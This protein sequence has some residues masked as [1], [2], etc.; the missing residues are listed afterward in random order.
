MTLV[1]GDRTSGDLTGYLAAL[2]SGLEADFSGRKYSWS[3]FE[4]R[5]GYFCFLCTFFFLFCIFYQ[6]FP[7]GLFPLILTADLL[8]RRK[9]FVR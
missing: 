2:S 7:F 8:Q 9:I 1:L 5:R 6:I 4:S 3:K